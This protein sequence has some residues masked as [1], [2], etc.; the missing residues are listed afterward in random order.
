M[1]PS[2]L[3][4]CLSAGCPRPQGHRL[5]VLPAWVSVGVYLKK[6]RKQEFGGSP[7]MQLEPSQTDL[8]VTRQR[9]FHD[10]CVLGGDVSR[11]FCQRSRQSP[12]Q[13]AGVEQ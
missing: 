4:R 8:D 10:L 12:V 6:L 1:K 11:T 2:I 5:D 13:L 9:R 3:L 7:E